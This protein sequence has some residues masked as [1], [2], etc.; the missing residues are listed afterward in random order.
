L[1]FPPYLLGFP[2]TTELWYILVFIGAL[3]ILWI[4]TKVFKTLTRDFAGGIII[5][6]LIIV[7][8]VLIL[9]IISGRS[10]L[11]SGVQGWFNNLFR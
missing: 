7:F 11:E 3:V 5:F 2:M 10:T 4:L 9:N 8:L 6:A 1:R